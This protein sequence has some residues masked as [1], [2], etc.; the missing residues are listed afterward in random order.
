MGRGWGELVGILML[1]VQGGLKYYEIGFRR[2]G[3]GSRAEM[4]TI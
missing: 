3:P 1:G 4:L 2:Q